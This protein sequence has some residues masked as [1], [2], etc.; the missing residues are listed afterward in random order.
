VSP[1]ERSASGI[2][3]TPERRSPRLSSDDRRKRTLLYL[4]PSFG[5]V[6]AMPRSS[7]APRQLANVL[8]DVAIVAAFVYL[9]LFR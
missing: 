6:C 2:A 4:P 5:T 3:E 9:I 1:F 8:L 7:I